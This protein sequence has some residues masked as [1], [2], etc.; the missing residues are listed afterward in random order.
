MSF[1]DILSETWTHDLIS[2]PSLLAGAAEVLVDGFFVPLAGPLLKRFLSAAL[3]SETFFS[4]SPSSSSSPSVQGS[5]IVPD[6]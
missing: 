2:F 4:S 3:A 1:L 6:R 5:A